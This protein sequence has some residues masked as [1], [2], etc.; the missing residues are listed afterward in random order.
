M[1]MTLLFEKENSLFNSKFKS[2]ALIQT[3]YPFYKILKN[4]SLLFDYPFV[5]AYFSTFSAINK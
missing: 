5:N 2:L 1:Q 4:A 3:C